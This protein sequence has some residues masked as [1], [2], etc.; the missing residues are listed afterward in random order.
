MRNQTSKSKNKGKYFWLFVFLL[1]ALAC[2]TLVPNQQSSQPSLN[3]EEN[4]KSIKPISLAQ[5]ESGS[6]SSESQ[7]DEWIYSAS[8][9]ENL[10]VQVTGEGITDAQLSILD[11]NG[12]EIA[13]NDDGAGGLNPIANFNVST[14][15]DY[16]FQVSATIPG[17]YKIEAKEAQQIVPV[18]PTEDTPID[19]ILYSENFDAPTPDWP[20]TEDAYSV[21]SVSAKLINGHY[22]MTWS[23]N[24]E[25]DKGGVYLSVLELNPDN[26]PY[27]SEPYE[28][29]VEVN[30][31]QSGIDDSKGICFYLYFDLASDFSA[32]KSAIFCTNGSNFHAVHFKHYVREDNTIWVLSSST[33]NLP[34]PR[35]ADISHGQTRRL[36]I[37][38]EQDR[39]TF[40]ID[41]VPT[42]SIPSD[43][44]LGGTIG[45]GVSGFAP[46]TLEDIYI[47]VDNVIVRKLDNAGVTAA[48]IFSNEN[49]GEVLYSED[50]SSNTQTW[51]E[52]Y[53][54]EEPNGIR[55][56]AFAFSY[57]ASYQNNYNRLVMPE[58]GVVSNLTEP[59]EFTIEISDVKTDAPV[60]GIS[61]GGNAK[62]IS[63]L[64]GDALGYMRYLVWSDNS[65]ELQSGIDG[66][67]LHRN[68]ILPQGVSIADGG[69]HTI[70]FQLDRTSSGLVARLVID[71]V[72]AAE[73]GNFGTLTVESL[74][75]LVDEI[76]GSVF[77][78]SL[79]REDFDSYPEWNFSARVESVQIRS[80][81]PP[82][83]EAGTGLGPLTE[84]F[85]LETGRLTFMYP[86]DWN[87][88]YREPITDSL[89]ENDNIFNVQLSN[90]PQGFTGREN[91]LQVN[92]YEP[93]FIMEQTGIIDTRSANL[94][95]V[96]KAFAQKDRQRIDTFTPIRLGGK[97][98]FIA[99]SSSSKSDNAWMVFRASDQAVDI[100][101]ATMPTGQ[102]GDLF[103][104]AIA[105]A[106]TIDYPTPSQDE[107][108]AQQNLRN[109]LRIANEAD[110]STA[111]NSYMCTSD[112]L[113][114]QLGGLA[115]GSLR[116]TGNLGF[117]PIQDFGVGDYKIDD[118][119]RYF[120]IV[121]ESSTQTKIR[122][123]GNLNVNY[124][125][126]SSQIVPQNS[127]YKVDFLNSLLSAQLYRMELENGH[128]VVCSGGFSIK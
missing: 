27:F 6:L 39:Y 60:W 1:I 7:V 8:T 43:G 117:N 2:Q 101:R 99:Y 57:V 94:E 49:Y 82:S 105:I 79:V 73:Q 65:Y 47:E 90:T 59:Y 116:D 84:K 126:G 11:P 72:I 56:G 45:F 15:G 96:L 38:V 44:P 52:K 51:K 124:A 81:V 123:S 4:Q 100:V 20:D 112:A 30:N 33:D 25:D 23:E 106:K 29:E 13:Q 41:G 66:Y 102:G 64:F 125:D 61:I 58:A 42:Q 3:S 9:G 19:T 128:W 28:Y 34:D 77:F 98:A 31:A 83:V 121:E 111:V 103:P 80:I 46:N 24:E 95:D 35:D 48:Q 110:I 32:W 85:T 70:G 122:V 40:L 91:E 71:G 21:G 53:H 67:I 88:R 78:Q 120:E 26:A 93:V 76:D 12:K 36:G 127:F 87:F 63:T 68:G 16:T 89:A 5:E 107:G 50:F 37:R 114:L 92:V 109:F 62:N 69:D 18:Q 54:D 55:D 22:Q 14:S 118:T 115:F 75:P 74:Q 10:Q 119:G 17:K 108:E 113:L 86:K 104:T 97:E